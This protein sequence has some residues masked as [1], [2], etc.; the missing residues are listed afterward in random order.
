MTVLCRPKSEER[1]LS[2][3]AIQLYYTWSEKKAKNLLKIIVFC[4]HGV[5]NLFGAES[6]DIA[7]FTFTDWLL[8][9]WARHACLD[10]V[11]FLNGN[12]CTQLCQQINI[13]FN[14]SFWP[15]YQCG[16]NVFVTH[17]LHQK[18]AW[19]M[20]EIPFCLFFLHYWWTK[21]KHSFYIMSLIG[22]SMKRDEWNVQWGKYAV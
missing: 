11:V 5:K 13:Y 14:P 8:P 16:T 22:E 15:V 7:C 3:H 20:V 2:G 1:V 19:E 9:S 6:L 4:H 17:H 21:R 10:V 12:V 18:V